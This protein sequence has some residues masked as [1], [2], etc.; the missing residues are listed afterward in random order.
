MSAD[1]VWQ[2]S[3]LDHE[4]NE[5]PGGRVTIRQLGSQEADTAA[6]SSA[7]AGT[8]TGI[9]EHLCNCLLS[10]HPGCNSVACKA[11]SETKACASHGEVADQIPGKC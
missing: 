8:D 7:Q 10:V 3:A 11:S 6:V 9:G 5:Q 4:R 1:Q 2:R